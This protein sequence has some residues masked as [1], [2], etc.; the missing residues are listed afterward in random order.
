MDQQTSLHRNFL[1][2]EEISAYG[3]DM[4]TILRSLDAVLAEG[5][6]VPRHD[7]LEDVT[8]LLRGHIALLIPEV[9]ELAWGLPADDAVRCAALAGV[10]EARRKTGELAGAGSGLVSA[11]R[12]AQQLARVCRAL[13]HHY[14]QLQALGE[15]SGHVDEGAR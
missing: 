12:Y 14:G 10:R 1:L 13:V 6:P 9:L 8:L 15:V 3:I 7:E 4:R 2:K 11:W 5:A